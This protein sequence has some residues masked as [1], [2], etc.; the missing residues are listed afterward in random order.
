MVDNRRLLNVINESG[1]KKGY[2]A[3]QMGISGSALSNKL[4]GRCR[5]TADECSFMR[6][7]FGMTLEEGMAIFFAEEVSDADTQ[8]TT[9]QSPKGIPGKEQA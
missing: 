9:G 7:F 5:W 6:E 2:I 1:Y 3:K 4:A 8:E